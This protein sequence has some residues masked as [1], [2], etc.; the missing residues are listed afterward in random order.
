MLKYL[1]LI[2]KLYNAFMRKRLVLHFF[3][4]QKSCD[5]TTLKKMVQPFFKKVAKDIIEFAL[6]TL[7]SRL[8]GLCGFFGFLF[9]V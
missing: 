9:F 6:L 8:G 4:L 5:G 7:R 1:T 2:V 3:D